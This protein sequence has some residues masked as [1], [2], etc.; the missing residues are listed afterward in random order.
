MN[1]VQSAVAQ[2][3]VSA[4]DRFYES[5]AHPDNLGALLDSLH[6]DFVLTLSPGLPVPGARVHRGRGA[7][8][9]NVWGQLPP[10][11]GLRCEPERTFPAGDHEVVVLGH[12][13]GDG[14]EAP[15]AHV[16]TVKGGTVASLRQITDTRCWPDLA[17]APTEA[18]SKEGRS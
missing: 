12:Y 4:T 16:L 6:P 13:R 1:G 3:T 2:L 14:W 11:L 10:G 7:A 15:F 5:L 8:V 9:A 17:A 18:A